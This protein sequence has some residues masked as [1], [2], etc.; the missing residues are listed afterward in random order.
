MIPEPEHAWIEVPRHSLATPPCPIRRAPSQG[1]SDPGKLVGESLGELRL[2]L[3]SYVPDVSPDIKFVAE[4]SGTS[5]RTFQRRLAA[6]GRSYAQ[7]V[8]ESR[9]E[10]ARELLQTPG[11][12]VIDVAYGVGYSDPSHF[13]RAFRSLAGVTP[14]EFRHTASAAGQ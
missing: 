4:L 14:R 8:Q 10:L 1:T 6:H 13:A 2:L 7:L 12:K 3:R 5:V 9:F 11:V